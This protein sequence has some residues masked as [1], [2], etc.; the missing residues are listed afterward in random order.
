MLPEK[1]DFHVPTQLVALVRR[2]EETDQAPLFEGIPVG[3]ER[4]S[5]KEGSQLDRY[6][7][8]AFYVFRW[9]LSASC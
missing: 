2:A 3:H 8:T 6:R 7:C 5:E 4:H 9:P 1:P